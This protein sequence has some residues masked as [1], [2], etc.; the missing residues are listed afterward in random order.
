MD[1]DCLSSQSLACDF[2]KRVKTMP[3][4]I[5]FSL[6]TIC[7]MMLIGCSNDNEEMKFQT[8]LDKE[9]QRGLDEIPIYASYM[10][11]KRANQDWPDI[12]ETAVRDRQN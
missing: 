7:L 2:K 4:R 12:S 9:W 1:Y 6:T 10:G 3:K 5:I 11:D 8:L